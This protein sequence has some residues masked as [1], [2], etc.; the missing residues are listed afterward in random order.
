[1]WSLSSSESSRAESLVK[2][3]IS[4]NSTAPN[5]LFEIGLI[6]AGVSKLWLGKTDGGKEL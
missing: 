6:V 1:M 5:I 2:P 4:A 3:E